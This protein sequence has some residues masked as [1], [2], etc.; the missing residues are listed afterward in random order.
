MMPR[1]G[2]VRRDADGHAVARHDLDAKPSHAPAQLGQ[3]FVAGVHLHAVK[4]TAVHGDDG[5]LHVNQIVFAHSV[6]LWPAARGLQ[7]RAR[8]SWRPTLMLSCGS[9]VLQAPRQDLRSQPRAKPH[10]QARA[11][12]QP[13]P[14]PPPGGPG[15]RSRRRRAAW[16]CR[17]SPGPARAG[18]S[19]SRCGASGP[20]RRAGPAPR[21]APGASAIMPMPPR[22]GRI[23]PVADRTPS[24]KMS[25]EK[26][27]PGHL[28]D[29]AQR[30][31]R[32]RPR[33]AAAG[34]R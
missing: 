25:T 19:S 3:H 27:S 31:P 28:A 12:A 8:S 20:P 9:P 23:S 30:L 29:V 21:A 11:R 13:G 16:A 7:I 1:C 22:N 5:A 17:R 32:A 14:L 4:S 34:T 24:G 10:A 6:S 33:V 2:V 15:R 18:P 26:P